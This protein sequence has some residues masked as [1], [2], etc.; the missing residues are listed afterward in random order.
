MKLNRI[1]WVP[2]PL[3]LLFLAISTLSA[4]TIDTGI[5]GTVT[6]S[7]GAV[8]AGAP[9]TIFQPATGLARTVATNAEGSYEVRYLMPGEY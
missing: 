5:L 6:D 4:Q 9:V 3:L 2:S 7:T 1:A 8:V